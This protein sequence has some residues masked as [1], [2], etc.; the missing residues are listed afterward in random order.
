VLG[1]DGVAL[2]VGRAKRIATRHQRRAMRT[3][4]STCAIHGCGVAFELCHLHHIKYWNN[5]GFSDL[6][7]FLPLCNRHHHA[8]HEGGW[9]LHLATDR[10]LTVTLPDGNT[11][12]NP[13]PY[14]RAA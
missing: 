10:T 3:M 8:V 12:A 11:R 1:G 13:P 6:H 4:Y 2:D 9:L 7:N 5:G 14:A